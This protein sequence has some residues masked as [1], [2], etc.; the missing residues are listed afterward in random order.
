MPVAVSLLPSVMR[1]KVILI[2]SPAAASTASPDSALA[3][4][5]SF[6]PSPVAAV[7]VAAMLP[8]S[9]VFAPTSAVLAACF[10][11]NAPTTL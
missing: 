11:A 7:P 9:A 3:T 4:V 10:F 6:A 1:S 2:A 8:W 5:A